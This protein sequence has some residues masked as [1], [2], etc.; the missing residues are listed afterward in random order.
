MVIHSVQVIRHSVD[1]VGELGNLKHVKVYK[2]TAP[3][4]HHLTDS[5]EQVNSKPLKSLIPSTV[6]TLHHHIGRLLSGYDHQVW[7]AFF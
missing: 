4:D 5:I 7:N 3:H 2:A 1:A 6:G